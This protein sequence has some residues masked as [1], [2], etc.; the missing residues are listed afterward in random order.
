MSL[1]VVGVL[2][3]L[4]EGDEYNEKE[5]A[6]KLFNKGVEKWVELTCVYI[7]DFRKRPDWSEIWLNRLELDCE[8][9][10]VEG[11][12]EKVM[13][14]DGVR[15]WL[16]KIEALSKSYGLLMAFVADCEATFEKSNSQL[17]KKAVVSCCIPFNGMFYKVKKFERV[18]HKNFVQVKE[19]VV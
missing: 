11:L 4:V 17:V 9:E 8:S 5:I 7:S 16:T 14:A 18:A 19:L 1:P 2:G 3:D 13:Q 15:E 6:D 10:E 12:Y